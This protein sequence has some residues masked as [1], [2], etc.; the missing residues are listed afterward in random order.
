MESKRINLMDVA[1]DALKRIQGLQGYLQK[2]SLTPIEQGIMMIRASQINGC[3]YCLD[4]HTKIARQH[5]ETEQRIYMLN[6]WKESDLFSEEEKMMLALTEDI[7]KI[8]K[9]GIS[10]ERYHKAEAMFGK[11]KLAEIIMVIV[12]INAW[13]RIGIA[14]T[15]PKA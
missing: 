4:M 9:H 5:G 8:A 14:T 13:N 3:A 15:M 10:D 12:I 7:T 6:V 1:P 11:E 2:I